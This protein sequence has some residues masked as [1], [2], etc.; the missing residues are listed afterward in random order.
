M[1][2][3]GIKR[4][5]RPA[6]ATANR[7]YSSG[8]PGKFQTGDMVLIRECCRGGKQRMIGPLDAKQIY[9]SRLGVLH[10]EDIIGMSTRERVKCR[11]NDVLS[12]GQFIVQHPTLEEYV[13][14]CKR[15]TTPIYPKD[16]SA[17]VS[18]L[19]AG[20]SDCILEAGTGNASL[21][22]HLARAVGPTGMVHTV[23]RHAETAKHARGLV[24]QFQRGRLL[25]QITFHVGVLSEAIGTAIA[26]IS[27]VQP[28]VIDSIVSAAAAAAAAAAEA[29]EAAESE[30]ATRETMVLDGVVLDMPTPWTQLPHI[31]E[32]LKT[33]RFAVCYL[34]S[35]SQVVDLV[36]ACKAW[37]LLVEDIVEV[38][39]RPW[40][41]RA[42]TVRNTTTA[43]EQTEAED[44]MICRPT[45][46]P[47]GH[48]A[49]LVKLRKCLTVPT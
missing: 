47:V 5:G 35:M 48:T 25:P 19:D 11:V 30:A 49:F 44:T 7:W 34:P 18:L 17:I 38:D 13:L 33:D 37:P 10:H 20:P 36:R 14:R 22:M 1:R 12:S 46:T 3:I 9:S 42:A 31:Q 43:T 8:S 41:V 24:K 21:T 39:W 26:S 45:H 4:L 29:A 15:K 28:V 27:K 32:F 23:E 6:A 2:S 40:D 16:A